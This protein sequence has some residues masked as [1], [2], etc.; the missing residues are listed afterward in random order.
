VL[1]SARGAARQ[2]STAAGGGHGAAAA[3]RVDG[4]PVGA[5]Y[6]G[7]LQGRLHALRPHR[8]HPNRTLSAPEDDYGF[9][10]GPAPSVTVPMST[11]SSRAASRTVMAWRFSVGRPKSVMT[12]AW[13]VVGPAI[14]WR[15][16]P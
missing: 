6:A 10:G 13:T 12:V 3:A 11:T 14:C 4:R 1:Y 2:P 9:A 7:L 15:P 16:E 5:E 8:A